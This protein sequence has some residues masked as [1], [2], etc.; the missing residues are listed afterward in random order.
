MLQQ[1]GTDKALLHIEPDLWGYAM[2]KNADPHQVPVSVSAANPTDCS[3]QEGSFVGFGK[4]LISMVRKYAPNAR[5]GFHASGW[6][7]G[8]DI[9]GNTDTSVDVVAEANKA[10]DFLKACGAD[11]ADFVV[12]ETSDRDAGYYLKQGQNTFW[13]VTNATLPNFHQMFTW[14]KAVAERVG[15]PLLWWQ[16]PVGNMNLPDMPTQY[17]DNRVDYFFAHPDEVVGTH[18]VLMAFGPGA[19]DQ[20]DPGTDN[21]NLIAKTTAYEMDGG[22]PLS[23]PP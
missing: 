3:T 2:S 4:C 8:I 11:Q 20:T 14:A 1:I 10:A 22:E 17:R 5:V 13:D 12:V 21:G 23:C 15:R 18:A 16:L 19:A 7:T 6:M 9:G